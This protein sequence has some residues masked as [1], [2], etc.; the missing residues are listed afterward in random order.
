MENIKFPIFFTTAFMLVVNII[1]FLSV[2][3]SIIAT[4]LFF[5]PFIVIWMVLKT[6]KDGK[7]SK[8]TFEMHWYE[9]EVV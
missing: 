6:L 7:P 5:A 9:D 1:P 4:L 3:Y 2:T 8:K